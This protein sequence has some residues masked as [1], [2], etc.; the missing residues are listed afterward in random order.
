M[1]GANEHRAIF[2]KLNK[3]CVDG[4]APLCPVCNKEISIADNYD[5]EYIKVR[6]TEK[7]IHTKCVKEAL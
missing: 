7:F 3:L 2:N 4:K 1:I 5:I 6:G